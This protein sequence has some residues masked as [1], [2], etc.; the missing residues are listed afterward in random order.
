VVGSGEGPAQ[1]GYGQGPGTAD[2]A[3]DEDGATV[4]H[5][6]DKR[7][8]GKVMPA[9]H[10]TNIFHLKYHYMIEDLICDFIRIFYTSATD[11]RFHFIF[12]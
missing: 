2:G 6:T 4:P 8:K 11:E 1:D 9:S 5:M 12:L 3:G 10:Q 7:S